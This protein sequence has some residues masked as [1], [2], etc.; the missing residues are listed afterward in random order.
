MDEKLKGIKMCR[1]VFWFVI[2][3]FFNYWITDIHAA[4]IT[5][6][7][8]SSED[9]SPVSGITVM[10]L[11]TE[12]KTISDENGN[13]EFVKLAPGEYQI[14]IDA[15]NWEK[16]LSDP[17]ILKTNSTES[18]IISLSPRS[19]MFDDLVVYG[20]TKSR[21][22]ITE[23]PAAVVLRVPSDIDIASRKGQVAKVMEGATGIDILRSG[24][25]DF[26]VNTRGFNS[27]LN[28]RILV[29][30]DGRDVSMPLLGAME[31]NSFSMPLDEFARVELV[32]GPSA[33]LYGANAFNGVLN[34]TSYSPK[35]VLG[36]KISLLAGDYEN[37]QG[38][39]RH[40]G[41]FGAFSYKVTLGRSQ[42]LNLSKRRDSLQFLDYD[43]LAIERRVL[44]ED[45]RKTFS[46]YGSLRAD[47]DLDEDNSL[48]AELGYSRSGNETYVF[49][50]GRTL[51][52]DVERPY[53]RAA[54]N[55]DNINVSAHYMQR[56]VADTMWLLVPNAPLLDDSKDI[57]FDFRHNFDLTEGLEIIWGLAQQFQFIRTSGTS[58]PDDVDADYTGLYGQAE[59]VASPLIKLVG[60][61][62]IDRASIHGTQFS[63][64]LAL[65]LSPEKDHQFRISAGRSFQRP[66][67]SELY[68]LTPDAPAFTP[69]PNGGSAPPPVNFSAIEKAIADSIATLRG[70]PAPDLNLNLSSTRAIALGNGNLDVE[71]NIGLEFGYKG[72]FGNSLFITVDVYYNRL[73]DFITNFLPGVNSDV[74]AWAPSLPDSLSEYKYLV[75][76]M[77]AGSITERDMKRLSILNG[78]PVFVVSNTNIGKV[79][80]YGIDIGFNYYFTDELLVS[81]NYSYYDFEVA[82][83]NVN[84]PLL[85]NT[86]P[87]K[88]NLSASYVKQKSFDVSV[89]FNYTKGYD[90]LAGT[91]VGT[92]PSYAIVN[93]SGGIYISDN[94][95]LGVNIFN[96][97]NRHFYQVFGGTYL[98]RLATVKATYEF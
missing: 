23:S 52:K 1:F 82:E 88:L 38:D 65:V 97:L 95:N 45:D 16:Y 32:R 79:D 33:S 89:S 14:A 8:S 31:W 2:I 66:N 19:F 59:W 12:Y 93:L 63:P 69:L 18:V 75:Y 86:S 36:T 10:L 20:A 44:T 84:Q 87:H 53:F 56:S 9:S 40:A 85:A 68:R 3:I 83:A 58:I 78:E 27:G 71:K 37:L 42:S 60:S 98:P 90:W 41:A 26:I 24:S 48:T 43:G 11:D 54:Y 39:I 80:Q 17:I 6:N 51:V 57:F 49:G 7:L 67:Y 4:E 21:E 76:D 55:S 61:A 73:T 47:Y 13:F 62:R 92:V 15:F 50:L 77:V 74:T 94:L 70:G 30:Q 72:I 34:L 22:K 28:R 29:L 35:E 96:L 25:S 46:T 64:R 5:G 91:Y 81:G